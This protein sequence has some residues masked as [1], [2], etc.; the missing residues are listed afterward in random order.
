MQNS[1]GLF[2]LRIKGGGAPAVSFT[3]NQGARLWRD[4]METHRRKTYAETAATVPIS[5]RARHKIEEGASAASRG[6]GSEQPRPLWR[7]LKGLSAPP[8]NYAEQRRFVP[9]SLLAI[10]IEGRA[11]QHSEEE[12]AFVGPGPPLA[13]RVGRA[14]AKPTRG[15]KDRSIW[16]GRRGLAEASG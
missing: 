6:G 14:A 13:M 3:G 8:P 1:G 11:P 16:S 9:G 5:L 10:K 12:P 4:P 2:L 7:R 15:R